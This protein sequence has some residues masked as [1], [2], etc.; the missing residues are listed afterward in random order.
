VAG[1]T[2][3]NQSGGITKSV[4][5]PIDYVKKGYSTDPLLF[6]IASSTQKS[7]AYPKVTMREE[8]GKEVFAVWS[9]A[10]AGSSTEV[11]FD[12]SHHLFTPPA[13][14]VQYQFIFERQSGATGKYKF[15]IDAPLG[16]VFKENDLASFIYES[17][18]TPGRLIIDVTLKSL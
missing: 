14:G 16:Y 3:N 12:Y 1:T 9:R 15:E 17:T 6:A 5:A 4:P 7:F 10:Y 11:V 8:S 13:A 2:L 18:S